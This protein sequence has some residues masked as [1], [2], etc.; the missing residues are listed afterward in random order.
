MARGLLFKITWKFSDRQTIAQINFFPNFRSPEIAYFS[1]KSKR[2]M[3]ANINAEPTSMVD[4]WTLLPCWVSNLLNV[5]ENTPPTWPNETVVCVVAI[6]AGTR[7]WAEMRCV[8]RIHPPTA[9]MPTLAPGLPQSSEEKQECNCWHLKTNRVFSS[10][11]VF[12][13]PLSCSVEKCS[14][15]KIFLSFKS[16]LLHFFFRLFD[17]VSR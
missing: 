6:A 4:F 11:C 16:Q 5:S 13:C 1:L 9:T 17:C 14:L 15:N 3:Q 7:S 8:L 12:L 2:T 10:F